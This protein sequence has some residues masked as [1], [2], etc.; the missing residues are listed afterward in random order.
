RLMSLDLRVTH[1][2]TLLCPEGPEMPGTTKGCSPSVATSTMASTRKATGSSETTNSDGALL[3]PRR[4]RGARKTSGVHRRN[5]DRTMKAL[6]TMESPRFQ[7]MS[8]SAEYVVV[9]MS[10]R[11]RKRLNL[12]PRTMTVTHGSSRFLTHG[13]D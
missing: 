10:G 1:C 12:F 6:V 11:P 3:P 13:G 2:P 5:D 4:E 9:V 7:I 8:T